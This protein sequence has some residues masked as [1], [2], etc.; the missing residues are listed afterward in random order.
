MKQAIKSIGTMPKPLIKNI[1]TAGLVSI[2]FLLPAGYKIPK[3]RRQGYVPT[4]PKLS[5]ISKIRIIKVRNKS[6]PII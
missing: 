6:I 5:N 1:N 3:P 4:T 2:Y